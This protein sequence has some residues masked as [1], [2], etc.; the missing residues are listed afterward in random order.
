MHHTAMRKTT[1]KNLKMMA[2]M[3][4][5]KNS[6]PLLV[7]IQKGAATLEDGLIATYKAK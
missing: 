1:K 2:R 7:E 4:N 5:N 6:H 3:Q